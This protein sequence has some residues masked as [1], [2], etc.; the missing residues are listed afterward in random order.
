M[1]MCA[2]L[3]FCWQ[4]VYTAEEMTCSPSGD[5]RCDNHRCIPLRWRCDGDNDCGDQSD[6]RNCSEFFFDC[7]VQLLT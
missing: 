6:E 5:F 7:H 2:G 4:T 3:M 1:L